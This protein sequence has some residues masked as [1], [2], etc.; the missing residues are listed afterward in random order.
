MMSTM[1]LL[2]P[3]LAT[4]ASLNKLPRCVPINILRADNEEVTTLDAH[5]NWG[6]GLGATV[7]ARVDCHG[8]AV[9]LLA[10]P[11]G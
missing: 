2:S 9:A 4:I 1:H 8:V 6:A 3:S 7:L 5:D 10:S 11:E